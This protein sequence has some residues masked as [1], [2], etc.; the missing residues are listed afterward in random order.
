MSLI[1]DAI[2]IQEQCLLGRH[3]W[4]L[5]GY[6]TPAGYVKLT[7]GEICLDCHEPKPFEPR[8]VTVVP[9]NVEELRVDAFAATV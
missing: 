7:G 5:C 2:A 4:A 3:R 8:I 9:A 1:D 6:T